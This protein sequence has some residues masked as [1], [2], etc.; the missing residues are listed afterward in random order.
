MDESAHQGPNSQKKPGA[1]VWITGLSGSGKTTIAEVLAP[2]LTKHG[3]EVEILDGDAIRSMLPSIGFSAVARIQHGRL[4]AD[5]AAELEAKGTIVIVSL[6]SPFVESRDY[7]RSRAKNFLEVH[8]S[9]PLTVCENRDPK[10][11]YRLA[12]TGAIKDFTGIDSPYEV[13]PT[14]ELRIDTDSVSAREAASL[15]CSYLGEKFPGL[16]PIAKAPPQNL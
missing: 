5:L 11:L 8:L 4:V 10:G 3:H 15:I 13:P 16:I 1:V 7:A 6:I 12:R 2:M 14:P 9:T